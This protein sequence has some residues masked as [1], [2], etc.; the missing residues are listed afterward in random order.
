MKKIAVVILAAGK[1]TRMK[2][3]TAKVLHEIC[4]RP[5]IAFP[6][7]L[8]LGLKATKIVVVV[9]HQEAAVRDAVRASR[10]KA[11]VQ[12]ALQSEQN[13]TGHAV[14]QAKKVLKGF[15]GDVLV[16]SG[17]VPLLQLA[18]LRAFWRG[19]QR[20]GADL[21]VMTTFAD[22]PTGYGRCIV[23]EER[24]LQR[25]VEHKD[26]TAEQRRID[27]INAGIY[28]FDAKLLWRLLGKIGTANA[29]REMYLTDAIHLAAG[30][31][32]PAPAFAVDDMD[33]VLGVNSRVELAMATTAVR[34]A[35]NESFMRGGVT[36]IDP[37]ATYID[38]GV[39]IGRDTLIEPGVMITGPTRIGRGCRIGLGAR[40]HAAKVAAGATVAAHAILGKTRK[41][42]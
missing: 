30:A 26:A 20:R 10:P 3:E 33:E 18:T 4:G 36:M 17:D 7:D 34:G 27:E 2:S 38:F 25:I 14:L 8:A 12:F 22:D 15:D 24:R 11:D 39:R 28:L 1:G 37:E 9:G 35:I 19:H 21:S 16:L 5:M 42:K 31:G 41:Y 6:L 13:G 32:K 40:L 29:Q 23:D